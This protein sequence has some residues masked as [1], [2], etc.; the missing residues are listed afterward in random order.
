MD[1]A[2]TVVRSCFGKQEIM[3]SVDLGAVPSMYTVNLSRGKRFPGK[4]DF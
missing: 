1:C 3:R 2:G 4:Q